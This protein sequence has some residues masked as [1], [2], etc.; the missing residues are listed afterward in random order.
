MKKLNHNNLHSHI[1][2]TF[3]LGILW[4]VLEIFADSFL[5][6][7]NIYTKGLVFS[8]IAV[9]VL[10]FSKQI[11]NYKFSL[12]FVAL[13]ALILILS[14][15][16]FSTNILIAIFSEALIAEFISLSLK[17][18]NITSMAIG[19]LIFL[20]SFIHGLIFHGSLPGSYI[21]YLYRDMF[22]I[23]FGAGLTENITVIIL[24]WGLISIIAGVLSGWLSWRITLKFYKSFNSGI[25]KYFI[26]E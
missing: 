10:I 13:I 18:N 1:I 17:N 4:G 22:T 8:F 16:G 3:I 14:S 7:N 5:A 21:T 15:K 9:L 12:L 24:F 20:Y 6:P 26:A 25:N 19:A 2:N 23:I 11:V